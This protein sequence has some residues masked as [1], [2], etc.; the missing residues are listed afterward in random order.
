VL[1]AGEEAVLF[2]VAE[3]VLFAVDEGVLSVVAQ[4]ASFPFAKTRFTAL[5]KSSSSDVFPP[6]TAVR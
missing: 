4:T 2:A 1:F 5:L 3:A 6:E